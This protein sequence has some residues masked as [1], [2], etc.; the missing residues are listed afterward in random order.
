MLPLTHAD[1]QFIL[2]VHQWPLRW[3]DR[4]IWALF[5]FGPMQPGE[6]EADFGPHFYIEKL[7]ENCCGSGFLAGE[8]A[9]LMARKG[10]T[11]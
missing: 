5:G 1:S 8:A 10:G 7:M 3:Y 2:Y 6:V 4:L 9:Y 11:A